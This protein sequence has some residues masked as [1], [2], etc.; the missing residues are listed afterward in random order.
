MSR[1]GDAFAALEVAQ[2]PE[3]FLFVRDREVVEAEAASAQGPLAGLLLAVKNNVDVAGTPTTAACPTFADGPADADAQAVARLRAAGAT[4]LG[5]TNLDQFATGLVGQRSPHGGVRDARRPSYVSGGSSSGS[6]VSV[7]LGLADVAIGT[8][9]AG[10]G[11]VPAMFQGLV[12]IKPTL[13]VAA[14]EGVLP[15]CRSWD[16]VTIFARDLDTA[17]TAMGAMAGGPGT[18]AWPSDVR[19]AAPTRPRVAVP[20][21][22]VRME[23]AW[24]AAFDDAIARLEAGGADVVKVP[25]QDFLDAALLLY[26][27]ALVAERHGAVGDFVDAHLDDCD[28]T[29]GGI[30]SR[31][32]EVSGSAYVRDTARLEELRARAMGLVEGCD[33]LVVPTAPGHPTQ[34]ALAAAPV[35]VNS[36]VGT[37]T[38]FANLFDLCGVAVPTGTVVEEDGSVAQTGVTV[39]GRAFEDAVALDVARRMAVLPPSVALPGAAPAL[40]DPGPWPL[41]AGAEATR[42]LVVGAHLPGQP[43][44]HELE[45]LGARWVGPAT[46]AASYRLLAL[47]T[48]PPKPGLVR[49]AEGGAAIEGGLWE[50]SPAAL[51]RFLAALPAPMSLGSV[52]LADGSCVTG[53]GVAADAAAAGKDITSFG[54]WPAYLAAR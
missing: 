13:G 8:D 42:L 20:E 12:G 40:P 23:P 48:T 43:L 54:G 41:L 9:T 45:A 14:V 32:G 17:A 25:F 33:V 50:L 36:W 22:L 7:A 6:A 31:A 44:A 21:T 18:R 5:S 29:V 4:V 19:L 47:D 52:E 49:E 53:F 35:A 11:R 51:G 16:A 10:S 24:V 37:Y 38:N 34:A 26:D 28:P 27:G 2:R 15:A 30:V 1:V 46:T 3:V 39:L